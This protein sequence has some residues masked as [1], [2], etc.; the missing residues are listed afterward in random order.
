MNSSPNFIDLL[1]HKL[2]SPLVSIKSLSTVLAYKKGDKEVKNYLEKINEKADILNYRIEQLIEL[3]RL[4]AKRHDFLYEFFNLGETVK[5]IVKEF[6]KNKIKIKTGLK[7]QNI[8]ADKKRIEMAIR[9][10]IR[11]SLVYSGKEKVTLSMSFNKKAIFFTLEGGKEGELPDNYKN[12]F[13]LNKIT[14]D[15]NEKGLG[16]DLYL[17]FQIIK[18]HGGNVKF[19]LKNGKPLFLVSVPYK[20]KK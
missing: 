3:E 6:G 19:S 20:A 4:K 2:K 18:L 13:N 7:K 17:A 8:L 10:L 15:E 12:L 14:T 11:K 5:D 16:V 1:A 9:I